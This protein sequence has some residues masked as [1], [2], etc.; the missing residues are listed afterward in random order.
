IHSTA[1]GTVE[2]SGWQNG[3]GNVVIIKHHGKYSTLYAHQSRIAE[4]ITKGSKISQG[5]L[6]GYVGATGWATGPH[7][8][9]EFRV[10]NQ[11]IDPLSVDLP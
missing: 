7:L 5:Q 2:F 1:D 9:Y 6:I 4:G 11:P 3:Y 8:H 10:D